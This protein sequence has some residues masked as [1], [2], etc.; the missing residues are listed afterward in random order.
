MPRRRSTEGAIA[1]SPMRH[2]ASCSRAGPPSSVFQPITSPDAVS[3]WLILSHRPASVVRFAIAVPGAS[4]R[5]LAGGAPP[6]SAPPAEWAIQIARFSAARN[7]IRLSELKSIAIVELVDPKGE[8][9]WK[10]LDPL[11]AAYV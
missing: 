4:F 5:C 10:P 8:L 1:R 3:L 9:E 11:P 6:N 7:V 2:S